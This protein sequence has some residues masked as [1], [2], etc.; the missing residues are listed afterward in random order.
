MRHIYV[1]F[2]MLLLLS[3]SC[4]HVDSEMESQ[5]WQLSARVDSL[6]GKVAELTTLTELQTD[7]LQYLQDELM[8]LKKLNGVKT[9]VSTAKPAAQPPAPVSKAAVKE[10]EDTQCQAI[11]SSGK[12]CSRTALKGSKYC[13]QHKEIFEPE[14]PK[15]K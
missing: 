7:E 9:A 11:T 15:K 12:R 6:S 14:I 1:F 4:S 3:I 8:E 2:S 5:V 13:Y 10:V